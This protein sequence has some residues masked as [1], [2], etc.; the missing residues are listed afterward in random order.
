LLAVRF[1]GSNLGHLDHTEEVELKAQ[2]HQRCAAMCRRVYGGVCVRIP[3]IS[4]IYH[5]SL[6]AWELPEH[7]VAR[8]L[9]EAG[10][11]APCPESSVLEEATR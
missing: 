5:P 10:P 6:A 8:C 1:G 9:A 3:G 2:A 4:A 7:A 11:A